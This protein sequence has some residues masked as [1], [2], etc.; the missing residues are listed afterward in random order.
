[1]ETKKIAKNVHTNHI[2][3]IKDIIAELNHYKA[4][5]TKIEDLLPGTGVDFGL[6]HVEYKIAKDQL[7]DLIE[8]NI[9]IF[10]NLIVKE[11]QFFSLKLED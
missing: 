2:L 5:R 8:I 1:M 3:S 6:F 7:I 9:G 10:K 11:Y 4:L